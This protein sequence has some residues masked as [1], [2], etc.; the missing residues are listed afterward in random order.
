M[1]KM[2]IGLI[3][4][5]GVGKTTAGVGKTLATILTNQPNNDIADSR[6]PEVF[7]IKKLPDTPLPFVDPKEPVFNHLK[8]RQTC[9]KKRKARK[10]KR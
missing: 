6:E 2:K 10:K 8:H 5:A 3:G 1:D 7:I 9:A 4:T